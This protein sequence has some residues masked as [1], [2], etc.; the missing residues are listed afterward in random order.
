MITVIVGLLAALVIGQLF[1][2]SK[3]NFRD[4][5]INAVAE[6]DPAL[7]VGLPSGLSSTAVAA[8]KAA[9]IAAGTPPIYA[10]KFAIDAEQQQAW[11]DNPKLRE[12]SQANPKTAAEQEAQA[13]LDA[14]KLEKSKLKPP[15]DKKLEERQ[16]VVDEAEAA[17]GNLAGNQEAQKKGGK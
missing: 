2:F 8:R 6:A 11:H 9:L 10:E 3:P 1:R 13:I 17:A 7:A 4:L 12:G 15:S 14:Q 5:A 16:E